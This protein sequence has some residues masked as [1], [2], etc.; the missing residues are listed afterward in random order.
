MTGKLLWAA[1]A[2]VLASGCTNRS[3]QVVI[4][5][6]IGAQVVI[7]KG[8]HTPEIQSR[9]PFS[10]RFEAVSSQDED[11]YHLRF[12]LDDPKQGPGT[13]TRLYGLLIVA[14][15]LD[16]EAGDTLVLHPDADALRELLEGRRGQVETLVEDRSSGSPRLRAKLILKSRAE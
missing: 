9:V 6:P 1:L 2:G 3:M 15:P 8:V 14:E 7:E 11:A 4:E 13:K 10:G 12:E 16:S 5:R